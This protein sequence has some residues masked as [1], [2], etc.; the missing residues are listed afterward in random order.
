MH[1]P[2]HL[3]LIGERATVISWE[4][5]WVSHRS[6]HR[7]LSWIGW[8]GSV[9]HLARLPETLL[10]PRSRRSGGHAAGRVVGAALLPNDT[11]LLLLFEQQFSNTLPLKI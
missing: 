8:R 4:R 2:G 9:E 1:A 11:P 6:S 10:W 7:P 5:P 3:A